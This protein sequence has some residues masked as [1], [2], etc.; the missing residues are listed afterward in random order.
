MVVV[1][2]M[3]AESALDQQVIGRCDVV[4]GVLFY[5]TVKGQI[6]YRC[7]TMLDKLYRYIS[8]T[9]VHCGITAH[10]FTQFELHTHFKI[11]CKL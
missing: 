6:T 3:F 1:L 10:R 8:F 7:T 2:L 5:R 9:L 4:V 11:Y